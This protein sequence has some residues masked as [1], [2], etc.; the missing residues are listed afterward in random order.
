MPTQ[1]SADGR[2]T[3]RMYSA[4]KRRTSRRPVALLTLLALGACTN[5]VPSSGP[6]IGTVMDGAQL[7]VGDPGP[8]DHPKLAYSLVT[9]DPTNVAML[10]NEPAATGFGDTITSGRATDVRIGVGDVLSATIFEAQA[11]GLFIPAEPGTRQGN[12]IQLPAEQINSDGTFTVPF[13]GAIHAVG[14][15]PA[16]LGRAIAASIGSRAIEPQVIV[17]MQDRR[18]NDVSV[19][20]DVNTSVR[21]GIDPGGARLLGAIARSG[22]PRF[23]TYESR[24]TLQR[25]GR[26]D[27]AM[28]ADILEDPRQ[29]IELASGDNVIVTHAPR[30]FLALGAIGQSAS[31][32]QLNRRFAFEDSH[33]SMEAAI[34]RAGDLSDNLANPS[35]V[36]LFRFE[37][38]PVLRQ[39]GL[40]IAANAPVELPTVYRA[41]FT[42]ASTLFLADKFP[43]RNN[44]ILFVSDAPAVDYQKFLSIILPF[45]QSGSNLR[46]FNP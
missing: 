23:P 6:R 27:H 30:Y 37:H 9:L 22:G 42:N 43:M 25:G 45:A 1:S 2:Q 3:C 31:I 4:G 38:T 16:Q 26:S 35:A 8:S 41:D 34:A 11:G 10:A 40:P 24:V 19:T 39:M 32:T 5:F 18:S 46:A 14:L 20:G 29:N 17:T 28:M 44:D 15:T 33:L 21:F 13:G 12:F 7:K 36:F